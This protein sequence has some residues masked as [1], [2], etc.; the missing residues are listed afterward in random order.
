MSKQKAA[1]IANTPA[2]TASRRRISAEPYEEWS[3]DQLYQKARQIG[4]EG[5]SSMDK[6]Q[7]V[8]ALRSGN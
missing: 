2:K 6:R 3:K 8:R 4:I 1:R 5:R 7:L